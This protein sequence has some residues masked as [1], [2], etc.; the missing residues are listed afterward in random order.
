M[1]DLAASG[2]GILLLSIILKDVANQGE[3][4]PLVGL[5][6]TNLAE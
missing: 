3:L 6:N 5:K 2:G 1:N 4:N